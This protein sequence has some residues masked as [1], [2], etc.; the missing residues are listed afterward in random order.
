MR[1]LLQYKDLSIILNNTKNK[2]QS[3]VNRWTVEPLEPLLQL[4]PMPFVYGIGLA[5][6]QRIIKGL[7]A[8]KNIWEPEY[9]AVVKVFQFMESH[10]PIRDSESGLFFI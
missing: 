3:T 9:K 4:T 10:C 2:M 6:I 7:S 5:Y 1:L 8:I